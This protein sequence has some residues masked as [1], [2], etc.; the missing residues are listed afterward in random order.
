LGSKNFFSK[1][2]VK[3]FAALPEKA[4]K[5]GCG[6]QFVLV[7]AQLKSI[8]NHATSTVIFKRRFEF[9]TSFAPG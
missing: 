9:L 4:V 2:N 5:C 3:L 7:G 8:A 6:N 1:S